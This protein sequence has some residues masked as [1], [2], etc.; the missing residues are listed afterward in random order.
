M[1][2]LMTYLA[3]GVALFALAWAAPAPAAPGRHHAHHSRHH[4]HHHGG[5]NVNFGDPDRYFG[6]GPGSYE[7]FGYDCNW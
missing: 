6:V 5:V 3:A 4:V 1:N 2:K 7:C